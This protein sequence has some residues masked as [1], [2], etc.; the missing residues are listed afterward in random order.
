VMRYK[1]EC[2]ATTCLL[3]VGERWVTDRCSAVVRLQEGRG[4]GCFSLHL[5]LPGNTASMAVYIQGGPKKPDQTACNRSK[6]LECCRQKGP[7]LHSKSFKYSL[8]NLH[9]SS[10]PLKLGICLHSHV[11]EFIEL[12]NSLPEKSRFKF[13]ELFSVGALQQMAWSQNFSN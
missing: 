1:S 12:K 13:C 2:S 4:C 11:P 9:R 6:V 5:Q 8:P 3:S 7:N 10:L